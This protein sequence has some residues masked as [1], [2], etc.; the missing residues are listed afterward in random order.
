MKKVDWNKT[1]YKQ[2]VKAILALKTGDETER[3]LRDLLTESEIEEFAKRFLAAEMLSQGAFY[4][5][6]E[7]RTGLSSATVSR[8]AKWLKGKGRGYQTVIGR[9]HHNNS[10]QVGRGLS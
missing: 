3:F 2:L 10:I 7:E 1:E 6:I 5:A 8:V 4:S 9:I